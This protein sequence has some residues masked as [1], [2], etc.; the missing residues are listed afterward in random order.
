METS[1]YGPAHRL[2]GHRRSL[3]AGNEMNRKAATSVYRFIVCR[4]LQYYVLALMILCS[5][6]VASLR[7]ALDGVVNGRSRKVAI[8]AGAEQT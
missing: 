5:M 8:P 6:N 2:R 1:G 4:A 3:S 7:S